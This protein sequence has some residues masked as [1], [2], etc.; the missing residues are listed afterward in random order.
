MI[1]LNERQ[2][3]LNEAWQDLGTH[4][5]LLVT[6]VEAIAWA[7]YKK[8]NEELEIQKV[9]YS[10]WKYVDVARSKITEE[11]AT[12]MNNY[13]LLCTAEINDHFVRIKNENI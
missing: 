5:Q 1:K 9:D 11:L 6:V 4:N 12:L 3:L 13:S 7:S 2:P 8:Y 10:N